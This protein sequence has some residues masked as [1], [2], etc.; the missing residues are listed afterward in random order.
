MGVLFERNMQHRRCNGHFS[1]RSALLRPLLIDGFL[2]SLHLASTRLSSRNGDDRLGSKSSGKV[3]RRSIFSI[4]A[5]FGLAENNLILRSCTST[6]YILLSTDTY[7][8]IS[9]KLR[10]SH[11]CFT[12]AGFVTI[13]RSQML[14]SHLDS[15]SDP[16]S[17]A[18][19][20][21]RASTRRDMFASQARTLFPKKRIS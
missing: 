7:L 18:K 17:H 9:S 21:Y 15:E 1:T 16:L 19:T 6:W 20:T 11:N 3:G 14:I 10:N 4:V 8:M 5:G 2:A 13:W 12:V